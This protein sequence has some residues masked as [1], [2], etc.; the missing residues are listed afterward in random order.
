MPNEW[1]MCDLFREGVQVSHPNILSEVKEKIAVRIKEGEVFTI[2][3]QDG[4]YTFEEGES[5]DAE[6]IVEVSGR[7]LCQAIDGTLDMRTVWLTFAEPADD[8]VVKKGN[9]TSLL[10]LIQSMK[11]AY[12]SPGGSK[13]RINKLLTQFIHK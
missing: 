6:N 9:G 2:L 10:P 3:I 5:E 13:D 12:E 8:S 1:K 11:K 4:K 7:F